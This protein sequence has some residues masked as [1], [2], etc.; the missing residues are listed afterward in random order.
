MIKYLLN[1][2]SNVEEGHKRSREDRTS[3]KWAYILLKLMHFIHKYIREDSKE[4]TVLLSDDYTSRTKSK[5][6][7]IAPNIS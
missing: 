2:F 6:V 4:S 3:M 5:I 1:G 7:L